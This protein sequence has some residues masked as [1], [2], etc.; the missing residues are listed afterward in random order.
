APE[1]RAFLPKIR[2]E[3][4]EAVEPNGHPYRGLFQ[5]R[6]PPFAVVVNVYRPPCGP[7]IQSFPRIPHPLI[8]H[9]IPRLHRTKEEQH[10][11]ILG[12]T[13]ESVVQPRHARSVVVDSIRLGEG[14]LPPP[15]QHPHD[16]LVTPDQDLSSLL[17]DTCRIFGELLVDID[18]KSTRLNSSHV[19][20][21][22][23]VFCLK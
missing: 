10:A 2:P 3:L 8:A 5:L 1:N 4:G 19:K 16:G 20:I 17:R 15:E 22:Y 23:A 9:V 6:S 7:N 21:S 18:R 13:M 11:K 12:R 14:S